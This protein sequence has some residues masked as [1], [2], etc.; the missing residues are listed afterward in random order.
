MNAKTAL[1][2]LALSGVPRNK[3]L[4]VRR[5]IKL[6][7]GTILF[8]VV[9]LVF[10]EN[11]QIEGLWFYLVAGVFGATVLHYFIPKIFGPIIFG[12]LFCGIACWTAMV[13]DFLPYKKSPGTI[14]QWGRFRYVHF[15][16]SLA[17]VIVAFT[18]FNNNPI[19]QLDTTSVEFYGFT[20]SLFTFYPIT[21][22]DAALL[23]FRWFMISN[24]IYF[25][26]GIGLAFWLKDNRAFCKYV[27]PITLFLKATSRFSLIKI[28][29]RKED[30]IDCGK[31]DKVCPMDIQISEYVK[32]GSRVLSTEC[33]LC[34]AC[35]SICPTDALYWSVK[36]D[37]GGK[38]YLRARGESNT[39]LRLEQ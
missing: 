38:E 35:V 29:A 26:L 39:Q 22:V 23:F 4:A 17:V 18:V 30:C 15:A 5:R 6:L 2:I 13:L 25:A 19:A 32:Q 8:V 20:V 34:S 33:I 31:C 37:L 1:N 3:Q 11:I 12:R 27:C 9:G 24:A 14:L 28:G 7:I 21:Q 10:R 16:I 36:R